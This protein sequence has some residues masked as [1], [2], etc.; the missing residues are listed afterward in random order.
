M[1]HPDKMHTSL[2]K[3]VDNAIVGYVIRRLKEVKE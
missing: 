3:V 2:T 1:D